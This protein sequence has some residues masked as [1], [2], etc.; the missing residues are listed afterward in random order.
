MRIRDLATTERPR[1]RL[2]RYGTSGLSDAE[3]LAILLGNGTKEENALEVAGRMRSGGLSRI[4]RMT[5]DEICSV[6][7]VGFAKA[8]RLLAA[9]ELHRRLETERRPERIKSGR[10]ALRYCQPLIGH[11]EQE[12]FLVIWLDTRHQ[13]L[14]HEI[15]TRG[16]AGMSIAHPREVFRGAIRANASSV[17]VAHNHPS[18]DPSPS[19]EDAATTAALVAA[20]EVVGIPV[21]DHVVVTRKE[22]GRKSL[23]P[24]SAGRQRTG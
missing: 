8:C 2:R 16:L 10:D 9:F 21:L 7:G 17:I 3:L 1:E 23:T 5:L 6:R 4:S 19:E 12:H 20:G 24:R 13:V 11:L 18:G 14:G 15:V 22:T